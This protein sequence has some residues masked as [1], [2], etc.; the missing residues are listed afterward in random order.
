MRNAF[1]F[2]FIVL[3]FN[4]N[5]QA[6]TNVYHCIIEGVA[7]FSQLP[8][9]QD[10]KEVNIVVTNIAE[11][12]VSRNEQEAAAEVGNYL[13]GQQIDRQI[14][15]NQSNIKKLQEQLNKRKTQIGYMTQDAANRLGASSINDAITQQR[16]KVEQLYQ[17]KI[18]QQQKQIDQLTALK[19]KIEQDN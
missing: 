10:A 16:N 6:K 4:V 11:S 15:K 17:P 12:A 5:A 7:T 3:C 18:E 9:G 19:N 2:L 13:T 8:C 1:V 14:I